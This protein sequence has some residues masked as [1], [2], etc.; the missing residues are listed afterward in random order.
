MS[1]ND[2]KP[3]KPK[4]SNLTGNESAKIKSSIGVIQGYDGVAAVD[5]KH[6]IVIHAEAFSEAQEHNLLQPMIERSEDNFTALD[7]RYRRRKSKLTADSGFYNKNNLGYVYNHKIDAYLPD[8]GFRKR[9]PRF[10]AIEKYK[11]RNRQE[12]Q[13]KRITQHYTSPEFHYDADTH[14]CLC[15]AGKQ[16]YSNG[17]KFI[18]NGYEALRFRGAK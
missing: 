8:L 14:T 16:L 3:G 6:E 10:Q 2:E 18:L 4:K 7:K 12:Q 1:D 17:R 9:D 15:P 5:S 13:K 11:G